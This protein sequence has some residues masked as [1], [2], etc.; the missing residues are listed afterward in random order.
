M[1][2]SLE[3]INVELANSAHA[4][5]L[6]DRF[7]MRYPYS[8]NDLDH[9]RELRELLIYQQELDKEQIVCKDCSF[10]SVQE[11]ILTL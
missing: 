4:M 1:I 6:A 7:G 3:K 10:S 9:L 11:I 2:D 8:T 5:Y